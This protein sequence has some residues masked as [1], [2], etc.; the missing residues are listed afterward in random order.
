MKLHFDQRLYG[1]FLAV[2]TTLILLM[3]FGC[4]S[5]KLRN[6]RYAKCEKWQV[7]GGGIDTVIK[8]SVKIDTV[9]TDN[10]DLWLNILFEC[11]STGA[12][13]IRSID[14]LNAENVNLR[15][16]LK[17]NRVTIVAS[18][19]TKQIPCKPC[20]EKT[21]TVSKPAVLIPANISGWVWF[22]IWA[23]RVFIGLILLSAIALFLHWKLSKYIGK[24]NP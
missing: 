22:Q 10:S 1:L 12:V 14:S 18:V 13:L 21:T 5:E 24:R 23:G 11:D 7:C 4:N 16:T 6:K 17:D 15:A 3:V 20:I 8:E 9:I 19:P 2:L